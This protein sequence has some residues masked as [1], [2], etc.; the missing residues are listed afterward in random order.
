MKFMPRHIVVKLLIIRH[1]HTNT[2]NKNPKPTNNYLN[3]CGF[4]IGDHRSQKEVKLCFKHACGVGVGE[5]VDPESRTCLFFFLRGLLS[6]SIAY[7]RKL[8]L[9]SNIARQLH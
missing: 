1:T 9:R 3:E 5:G 6:E 7:N 8:F 2:E 4:L